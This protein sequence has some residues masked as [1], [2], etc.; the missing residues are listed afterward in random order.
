MVLYRGV[1]QGLLRGI[2][3]VQTMAHMFQTGGL[4]ARGPC[5]C[6]R[7]LRLLLYPEVPIQGTPGSFIPM[8]GQNLNFLERV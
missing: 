2:L 3:G 6:V 8:W 4:A 5:S 1:L 7:P